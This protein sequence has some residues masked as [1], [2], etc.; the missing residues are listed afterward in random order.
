MFKD[1]TGV[2]S[3][4]RVCMFSVVFTVCLIYI[5]QNIASMSH[6]HGLVSFGITEVS[7]LGLVFAAKVGQNITENAVS[8]TGDPSSPAAK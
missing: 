2:I 5:I 8:S 1:S 7:I 6:G 4:M 3:I